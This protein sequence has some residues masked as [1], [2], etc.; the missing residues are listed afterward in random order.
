MRTFHPDLVIEVTGAC[1]K[2]CKG[3][4]APNVATG[5]SPEIFF[6]KRPELFIGIVELNRSFHAV[7]QITGVTAIRGGEPTLHPNLPI[8]LTMVKCRAQQVVLET[9]GKWLLSDVKTDLLTSIKK[10]NVVVKISFDKMH[11]TKVS[12]LKIMT[13]LL[14]REDISYWIA[15]TEETLSEFVQTRG[16]CSWI[17]DWNIIYQPKASSE[18]EL[19]RPMIGTVNVRGEFKGTLTHKFEA[20]A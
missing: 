14:E 1:N 17:K 19:M 20:M 13:D 15:I 3:C 8:I 5:E 9:H 6:E 4:Y 16:L 11:G 10:N 2:A 18:A 7:G 12:D